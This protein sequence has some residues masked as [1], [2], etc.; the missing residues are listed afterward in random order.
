MART[1]A[2][3]RKPSPWT[4]FRV[5]VTRDLAVAW[6]H[7]HE[8]THP[9]LFFILTVSLFP[10][11]AGPDP[12]FLRQ[13]A[14]GILWIAALLSTL[15]VL[16]S[17]FRTEYEDG[18][19]EQILT[20]AHPVVLIVLAKVAAHW[21]LSAL[22]L[23]AVSVFLGMMLNLPAHAYPAMVLSLLVGTPAMSL[24]G[25]IGAGLT[26]GLRRRGLL[27]ALI[28]MPLYVPILIFGAHAVQSS[29]VQANWV[30]PLLLL[31]AILVL[32]LTLAP[33]ALVAAL[34]TSLH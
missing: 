1:S 14:P 17:L 34:K 19:L 7:L 9:L 21:I 30:S 29:I 10:L 26:V 13:L 11:A 3:A 33:F 6:R 27:L 28:V 12:V 8:G 4:V 16:D 25:A 24:I 2:P 18:T 31:G 22:P 23:V 15:L 32:S 5:S 20:S